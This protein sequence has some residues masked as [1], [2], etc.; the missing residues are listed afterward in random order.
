MIKANLFQLYDMAIR[1]R[2]VKLSRAEIPRGT[3]WS[4][5]ALCAARTNPEEGDI[6]LNDGMHHA[7]TKKFE[8]DFKKM[9]FLK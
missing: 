6:Y 7:L 9:G 5:V 3:R 2:K 1:I 8:A 4:Y